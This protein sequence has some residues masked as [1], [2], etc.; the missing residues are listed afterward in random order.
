MISV[1]AYHVYTLCMTVGYKTCLNQEKNYNL[2]A[3]GQGTGQVCTWVNQS[4][5][6]CARL[7]IWAFYWYFLFRNMVPDN[8][9]ETSI[10][11]VS[12]DLTL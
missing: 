10:S 11:S 4:Y 1:V 12:I 2:T 9:V 6:A 7:Y 5:H 3:Y 8:I